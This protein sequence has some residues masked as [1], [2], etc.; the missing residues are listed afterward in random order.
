MTDKTNWLV[1]VWIAL[2]VAAGL[3]VLAIL[4]R[5]VVALLTYFMA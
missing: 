5:P 3:A 2:C 4:A 1:V